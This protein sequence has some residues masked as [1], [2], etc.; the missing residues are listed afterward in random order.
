M[1]SDIHIEQPQIRRLVLE[2]SE[3]TLDAVI[4]S[5][6]ENHSLIY[7]RIEL[8]PTADTYLK[9]VENAVYDN[10]ALIADYKNVTVLYRTPRA[11]AIPVEAEALSEALLHRLFPPLPDTPGTVLTADIASM[12]AAIAFEV[13]D[14]VLGFLRRTFPNVRVIHP[15]MPQ[16]EWFGAKYTDTQRGKTFVNLQPDRLDIIIIGRQNPLIINTLKI[17]S[18]MDAFYY[19]MAA[20]KVSAMR[21]DDEIFVGGNRA[22]RVAVS[23][24]LRDYV[25]F[26][27]PA[28]F[29]TVMFRAGRASLDAPFEMILTPAVLK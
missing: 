6:Y 2:L 17:A 15:L 9:A 20:R 11:A 16:A 1:L 4:F 25:S 28:I 8:D 22:M 3:Q 19:I 7:E 14:D 13:P 24:L 29:P 23:E 5:E 18:A 10:P 27:M 26:V 12:K 21:A